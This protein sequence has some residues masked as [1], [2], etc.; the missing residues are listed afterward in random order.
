MRVKF[1]KQEFTP[2]ICFLLFNGVKR[3][4]VLRI[5]NNGGKEEWFGSLHGHKNKLEIR[6]DALNNLHFVSIKPLSEREV[7]IK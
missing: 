5:S 2:N 3:G 7:D 4:C 1:D 6:G